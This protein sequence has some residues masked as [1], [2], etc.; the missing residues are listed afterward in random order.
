MIHTG[1]KVYQ[2]LLAMVEVSM[3]QQ[4]SGADVKNSMPTMA[5][6]K[7][8][9]TIKLS[10]S[11]RSG[12]SQ[13]I[14]DLVENILPNSLIGV[15]TPTH[16]H[17]PRVVQQSKLASRDHY[18]G[19]YIELDAVILDTTHYLDDQQ[20]EKIYQNFAHSVNANFDKQKPF[21]FIFVQ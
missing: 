11:R 13:A 3:S 18:R 2:A 4:A 7:E 12:H 6:A 9:C 1:E 17:D 19:Q 20:V 21:F 10:V 8:F 16:S 15:A 14:R 5:W